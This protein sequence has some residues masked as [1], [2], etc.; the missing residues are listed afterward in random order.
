MAKLGQISGN[1]WRSTLAAIMLLGI[2][3]TDFILRKYSLSAQSTA[4]IMVGVLLFTLPIENLLSNLS[5]LKVG[6]SGIEMIA[7]E[8][9]LP[10]NTREELGGLS[11]HDVWALDDFSTAKI[12]V[13]I[14][15]MKPAQK[16]AAR[17]LIDAK[18]LDI[19]DEGEGRKVVATELG[20]RFLETAKTILC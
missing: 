8:M 3:I 20:K 5:T 13:L 11:S 2:G 10:S 12:K 17:T 14:G 16:V 4:L 7:N 15:Q 9:K 19:V 6:A 18:L 1:R